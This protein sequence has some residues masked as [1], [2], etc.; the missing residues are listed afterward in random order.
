ML[1]NNK[2]DTS[3]EKKDKMAT[4]I[5]KANESQLQGATTGVKMRPSKIEV[6]TAAQRIQKDLALDMGNAYTN[7]EGDDDLSIDHRSILAMLSNVSRLGNLPESWTFR[8]QERRWVY[9][10]KCHTY[11]PD[12]IMEN[13]DEGRYTTNW[14]KILFIAALWRA[15]QAYVDCGVVTPR[16]ISSVPAKIFKNPTLVEAIHANLVDNYEIESLTGKRLIVQADRIRIIPEGAGTHMGFVY[17]HIPV[18]GAIPSYF[19]GGSWAV[20]DIGHLS[21]DMVIFRDNDYVGDDAQSDTHSGMSIVAQAVT[22]HIHSVTGVLLHRTEIDAEMRNDTITVNDGDPIDITDVRTQALQNLGVRITSII[23]QWTRG[24]NMKGV[25]LT[26]GGAE[27]IKPYI[28]SKRL[29]RI[30]LAPN[31]PRA[32]VIGAYAYLKTL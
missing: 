32:N 23:E 25:I 5:K 3:I 1:A 7:I 28:E 26:G 17:G 31:A 21:T 27:L 15:F 20:I 14:Y 11:S 10:E 19:Q 13:V 22:D 18:P 16:I 29:P 6:I 4:K 24:R 2:C 12:A 8:F 30:T 9:G